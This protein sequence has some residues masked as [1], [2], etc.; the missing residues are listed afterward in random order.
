[1]TAPRISLNQ[2]IEAV[3]LAE[4]RQRSFAGG[5]SVKPMRGKSAEEYDLQRLGA[6]ARTLEWLAA[7]EPAI[8]A[9][10]AVPADC[11]EAAL[12]MAL[13]LARKNDL[14]RAGGPKR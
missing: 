13:E 10:A 11:R 2:Q 7:N 5:L 4:T 3:R 14:A 12:A 8:R 6:A 1:M 9:F